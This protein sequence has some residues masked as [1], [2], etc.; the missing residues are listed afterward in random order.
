MITRVIAANAV[1]ASHIQSGSIFNVH[2]NPRI[3][4]A[5]QLITRYLYASITESGELNGNFNYG[6]SSTEATKCGT[7]CYSITYDSTLVTVLS[8]LPCIVTPGT[9]SLSS[10]AICTCSPQASGS[11][12]RCFG[13]DKNPIDSPFSLLTFATGR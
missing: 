2:L 7:G 10:Y 12:V 6:I 3:I 4:G 11:T 13:P 8:I 9:P 1:G 5:N